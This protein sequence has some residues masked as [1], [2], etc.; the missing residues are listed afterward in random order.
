ML[1][2]LFSEPCLLGAGDWNGGDMWF[3]VAVLDTADGGDWS[4]VWPFALSGLAP[5]VPL[6]PSAAV[7]MGFRLCMLKVSLRRS[8][9]PRA[10]CRSLWRAQ[11]SWRTN[12]LGCQHPCEKPEAVRVPMAVGEVA[13]V[14]LLG[15]VCSASV[16]GQLCES[17]I[18]SCRP[19]D[20]RFSWCL[21]RCSARE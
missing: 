14:D 17:S 6:P 2:I 15:V 21:Y 9:L 4:C 3:N 10:V 1:P 5:G 19:V 16:S 12:D 13:V 20:V 7:T 11:R 8:W 18:C